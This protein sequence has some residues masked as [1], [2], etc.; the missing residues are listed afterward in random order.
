MKRI[1]VTFFWFLLIF[2]IFISSIKE[3]IVSNEISIKRNINALFPEGWGFFTRNPLEDEVYIYKYDNNNKIIPIKLLNQS[4]EN[5]FGFSRNSRLL[6]YDLSN[7][8]ELIPKD[9]HWET[10]S[11]QNLQLNNF[12]DSKS[13]KIIK[14]NRIKLM[15][16]GKYIIMIRKKIP[17]TW[18]NSGQE[19]FI[20]NSLININ[21]IN[22]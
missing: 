22:E 4:V 2:I 20:K 14:N 18:I 17:Y 10:V 3:N 19:K 12:D 5:L 9:A 7:I 13:I 1:L 21:L 15:E 6:S 16:N 8:I 11:T